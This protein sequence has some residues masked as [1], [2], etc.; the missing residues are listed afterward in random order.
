MTGS[1][2]TVSCVQTITIKANG[3]VQADFTVP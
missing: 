3:Y 2:G 1:P